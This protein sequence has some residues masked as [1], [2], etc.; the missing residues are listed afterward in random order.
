V[1]GGKGGVEMFATVQRSGFMLLSG[2]EIRKALTN[3]NRGFRFG[4]WVE[5]RRGR[6]IDPITWTKNILTVE[7]CNFLLSLLCADQAVPAN[8]FFCPFTSTTPASGW[9]YANGDGSVWAEWTGY[10]E[11]ARPTWAHG[12]V[13]AGSVGSSASP[14]SFTK[15]AGAEVTIRGCGLVTVATKG[16][17]TAG[18]G[19]ILYNASLFMNGATAAPKTLQSTGDVLK[20]IATITQ[21]DDG[22]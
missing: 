12:A 21:Q 19:N 18:A 2:E 4:S 11:A 10:D 13:S 1:D 3:H 16:H 6:I 17:H 8:L 5:D 15:S 22:V 9:T 14:V 20:V 7:G